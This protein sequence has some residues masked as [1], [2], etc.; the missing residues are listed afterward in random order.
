MVAVALRFGAMTVPVCDVWQ[1]R[2]VGTEAPSGTV[3]FLFTDIEGSTGLWEAYPDSMRAAM[4]RHDS[5]L[6]SAFDEHGG[7]VFSI[8]GDGFG[9]AFARVADGISAAVSAQE[10]LAAEPWPEGAE[11][12]VRMGVH[13]GEVEERDGNYFGTAVN[14]AARLMAL[15]HGGQVLCSATTAGVVEDEVSLIDLGEHGLRDLDRPMHVFQVGAGRFTALRSLEVSEGNLP[16][17]PTRF[18]GRVDELGRVQA[19]VEESRLVTLTGVGGVGKTRLAL[20][21]AAELSHRYSDGAWLVELAGLIDPDLVGTTVADVLGVQV[22]AGKSVED[23]L[24]EA[25]ST[26]SVLVVLDNCEHVIGAAAD[27]ASRLVSSPG[28][29]RVL[30]TSREGLGVAGER[31]IAVPPMAVPQ[32][33]TPAPVL[34]SDAV[35]LFVERAADARDGFGVDENDAPTLARLCRRLDGIP[36]AIELAAARVRSSSPAD[37]LTQLDHRF[38]LL[39]AGRRTAPTRQQTLHNAIDWSYGLLGE[40]ERILLRRL[41]VFG[42]GFD[43]GAVEAITSDATLEATEVVDILDRLVDK[44]LVALDLSSRATRYRLLESIRDYA[45]ER[46][47]ESDETSALAARHARYFAAFSEKAGPGLRGPD[48]G[49]WCER[50]EVELEN[51]RLA[52]T[53]AIETEEADLAL[54]L[55]AGLAVS[56]YPAGCPFGDMAMSAAELEGARGHALRPLALASAAWSAF[57]RGE[58]ERAT[59][60]AEDALLDAKRSGDGHDQPL[61]LGEVLSVLGAIC[62]VRPGFFDRAVAVY[63]ERRAVAVELDDPYQILQSLVGWASLHADPETAE[64]AVRLAPS[65]GNPT[66]HSYALTVLAMLITPKDPVRARTLLDEAAGIASEVGNREAFSLAQSMLGD[67]VDT[68]GDQLS[69]ARMRLTLADQNFAS[70]D[71]F[72]AWTNL[73]GVAKNLNDVGDHEAAHIIGSWVMRQALS[74]GFD[75]R[76]GRTDFDTDFDR[77]VRSEFG[78]LEPLAAAMTDMDVRALARDRIRHHELLA[79]IRVPDTAASGDP[80]ST[81]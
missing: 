77:S 11:V 36:L 19:G 46:L 56:G 4:Q 28:T 52:L 42:G 21:A 73:Y 64:E 76:R 27:V 35:R 69:A 59:A 34:A 71:S 5:I 44:S 9:A 80:G 8:G 67:L 22:Q 32:G 53:W 70:D 55:V 79:G 25:F 24:A 75:P 37:I 63:E 49:A 3:T 26:R 45:F 47:E 66:M 39:S 31:V 72:F 20:Q 51:L 78:H 33:D 17:Q 60:L 7:Y 6:H 15:G 48:E 38:R 54:R 74:G 13:T 41:S 12:R 50:V 1:A 58:F 81:S 10:A 68:V 29:S 65:V 40:P 61:L 16:V 18:V 30:A 2:C 62:M 57:H 43:L 23:S 14:R